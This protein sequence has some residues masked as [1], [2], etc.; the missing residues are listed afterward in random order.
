MHPIHLPFDKVRSNIKIRNTGKTPE[1][2]DVIRQKWVVLQPE[3]WVRQ[4]LIH[5][6]TDV[7]GFSKNLM[8]IEKGFFIILASPA[9]RSPRMVPLSVDS[10]TNFL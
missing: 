9:L 2:W 3:E 6:F 8:A 10:T 4:Q 7:Y 5:V 1:I